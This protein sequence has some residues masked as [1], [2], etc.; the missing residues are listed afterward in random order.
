MLTE[1]LRLH[2]DDEDDNNKVTSFGAVRIKGEHKR[3]GTGTNLILVP[4]DPI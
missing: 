2:Y 1:L 3:D 4:I